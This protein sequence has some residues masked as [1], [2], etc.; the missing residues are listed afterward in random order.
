PIAA[1][2]NLNDSFLSL[3]I[4]CVVTDRQSIGI[5]KNIN[6][7]LKKIKINKMCFIFRAGGMRALQ[8]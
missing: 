3:V 5:Q 8:Q 1:T 4:V 2:R 7:D 6:G